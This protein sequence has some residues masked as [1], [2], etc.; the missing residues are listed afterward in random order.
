MQHGYGKIITCSGD[1]CARDLM[2]IRP[3]EYA[4]RVDIHVQVSA[5]PS[6]KPYNDVIRVK[7][8]VLLLVAKSAIN[9]FESAEP[10]H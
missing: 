9:S 5:M 4:T 2:N 3:G 6:N 8:A 7:C 10:N 1:I